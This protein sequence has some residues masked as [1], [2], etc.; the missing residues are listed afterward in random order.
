MSSKK[1][2]FLDNSN[3][4]LECKTIQAAPDYGVS[5]EGS[6]CN[7]LTGRKLTPF[8][9]EGCAMVTLTRNKKLIYC[10]VHRLVAEAFVDNPDGYSVAE[11]IDGDKTNNASSNIRWVSV[12]SVRRKANHRLSDD[13]VKEIYRLLLKG[14]SVGLLAEQHGVSYGYIWNIRKGNVRSHLH[15]FYLEGLAQKKTII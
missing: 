11:H 2:V 13:T 12:S 5:K 15:H 7:L 6:V 3:Y 4:P 10:R 14:V 9:Q 8:Y 1:A